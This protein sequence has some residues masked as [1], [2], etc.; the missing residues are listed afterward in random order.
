MNRA[1]APPDLDRYPVYSKELADMSSIYEENVNLFVWQRSLS[2]EIDTAI[3]SLIESGK[4]INIMEV[5]TPD[6]AEQILLSRLPKMVNH[7]G[8]V[9]DIAELVD[10]FCCLFDTKKVGLRLATSHSATCPRFHVDNVICRLVT[11]YNGPATQWLEH[12]N[13]VRGKLGHA[14]KG[15]ADESSGLIRDSAIIQQVSR[16]DIALLKGER[17]SNNSGGGLVHRSPAVNA[18]TTRVFLSLDL[19]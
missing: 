3:R 15:E 13:V 5:V 17:W 6:N 10:I 16:G 7:A 18:N 4:S 1:I 11:T 2:S 12:I 8:L 19:M 9:E 14:S